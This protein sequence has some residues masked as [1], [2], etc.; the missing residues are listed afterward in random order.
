MPL[1][2][3]SSPPSYSEA[4]VTTSLTKQFGSFTAVDNLNI[5]VSPGHIFGFLGPN[6]SGKS[7]TI[8]MLSG[9]LQLS[10]GKATV[11]GY[12]LATQ[13]ERIKESIGYMSQ[14]FSLYRDLTVRE[15]LDFFGQIYGLR[16]A[17]LERRR[18]YVVD[19][20]GIEPY[21]N[22]QA[23]QLSGGWKQRLALAAA[24]IHDP[25]L[26]FLDEPT[27]GIDP[28]ARRDLW[29]L[30]FDLSAAGKTLFVSTHYM[31]EA[32][33]CT[34]IAYIY[35]S[36]LMVSGTPAELKQLPEVTPLGTRRLAVAVNAPA[37]ALKA[38]KSCAGVLDSTLVEAEVHLLVGD[39]LTE[40]NI[41]S[42]L[43]DNGLQAG[44]IRPIYPSLEDVFVILTRHRKEEAL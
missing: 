20:V 11:V 21:L 2:Q 7:T 32:E 34:D 36:R 12:D 30:L 10:S 19:V 43:S 1:A 14:A 5:R 15:N 31:D 39:D 29:E 41:A 3:S 25:S 26:V 8:R 6:G 42:H 9:L 4:I 17:D 18:R 37:Q 35:N 44:S 38:F 22:R 24:I 28:V 40:A 27:A 16:G 13:S 33:R 23:G